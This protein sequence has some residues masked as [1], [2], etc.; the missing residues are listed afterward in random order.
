MSLS[1][2]LNPWGSV[3]EKFSRYTP[4]NMTKNP[5]RREIVFMAEVVLN[6]LKSMKEAHRV[7]VVKVT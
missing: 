2:A 7:A 4:E 3:R 6:P 5:Q 1:I